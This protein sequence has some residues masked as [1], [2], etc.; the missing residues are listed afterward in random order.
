MRNWGMIAI[1]GCK[2]AREKGQEIRSRKKKIYETADLWKRREDLR[3]NV[4]ADIL[5]LYHERDDPKAGARYAQGLHESPGELGVRGRCE[6]EAAE[7]M[8]T[9]DPKDE[10]G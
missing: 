4:L 7:Q 2:E 9:A 6:H 1:S 3:C 5:M 10:V 8:S